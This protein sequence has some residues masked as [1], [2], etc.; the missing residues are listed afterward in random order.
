MPTRFSINFDEINSF[1][2]FVYIFFMCWVSGFW[3]I[4]VIYQSSPSKATSRT[5]RISGKYDWMRVSFVQHCQRIDFRSLKLAP[6]Q[7]KFPNFFISEFWAFFGLFLG[8]IADFWAPI[9]FPRNQIFCGG[10]SLSQ[11]STS[12]IQKF[13]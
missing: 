1:D 6:P 12:T 5:S 3:P 13:R 4:L 8:S 9:L 11:A 7:S 10:A 2:L